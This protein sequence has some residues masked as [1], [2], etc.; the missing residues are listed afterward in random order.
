[1]PTARLRQSLPVEYA[2]FMAQHDSNRAYALLLGLVAFLACA[3]A[4]E[5]TVRVF[6]F[7][8]VDTAI[9]RR[10]LEGSSVRTLIEPSDDPILA[11]DLKANLRVFSQGTWVISG[12][13]RFRIAASGRDA[14]D[15]LPAEHIRIAVLGDS[16][17]FG[18]GVA[19]DDSYPERYRRRMA[20]LTGLPIELRN[21][22]VPAYN[23]AQELRTFEL[24][25]REFRPHV[26]IV[27]H[28]HNDA[29]PVLSLMGTDYMPAEFGDNPLHS[30]LFKWTLR[31][32]RQLR[33]KRE[34]AVSEA[35]H[36]RVGG[37]LAAG[38]LYDAQVDARRDLVDEARA[39]GAQVIAVLFNAFP[40]RQDT[41]E[42]DETYVRLHRD[43]GRRLDGM[44]YSVL[45]L[46]PAYQAVMRQREW[47][48]L[49]A[50]WLSP[51]DAHPNAEA[52]RFIA[53]AL[54]EH[55]L[56]NPR[57]SA[58]FQSDAVAPAY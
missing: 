15:G 26:L 49:R 54:V 53:D 10:A 31:R 57:L 25:A 19:Y 29:D 43:L 16:T 17:S 8:E 30:A 46:Y 7:N 2:A 36:R 11:F 12:P 20:E 4:L 37:Y 13:G 45:D 18:W 6:F 47:V 24:K 51:A 22:S 21:Y 44:G 48:D 35:E 56:H 33:H 42:S 14:D 50:W 27:H 5:M 58:V 3:A 52:H 38:P 32:L 28:D 23:A 34:S 40:I 1:V 55:T 39:G 41:Y 9:L